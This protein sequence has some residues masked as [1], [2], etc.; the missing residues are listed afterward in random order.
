MRLSNHRDSLPLGQVLQQAG[1]ISESQLE[2]ALYDQILFSDLRLGEILALRGWI[3]RETAD[4]FAQK[5]QSLRNQP[6]QRLGFYLKEAA[7]LDEEKV[8]VIISSQRMGATRFR[9]GTLAVIMGWIKP[10]TRDFFLEHLCSDHDTSSVA[11]SAA[12][13]TL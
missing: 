11:E 8:S 1:L 12:A 7:L 6:R 5:W 4:F 13:S 3:K 10:K 2:V 9:F